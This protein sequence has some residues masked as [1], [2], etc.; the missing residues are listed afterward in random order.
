M[1][2]RPDQIMRLPARPTDPYLTFDETQSLDEG[3]AASLNWFVYHNARRHLTPEQAS[4]EY[5]AYLDS[6]IDRH[7]IRVMTKKVGKPWRD[8]KSHSRKQLRINLNEVARMMVA[9]NHVA[10]VSMTDSFQDTDSARL[11]MYVWDD[12]PEHGI[13]TDNYNIIA[14][15]AVRYTFR[16]APTEPALMRELRTAAITAKAFL[17]PCADQDLVPVGNGIYNMA[18]QSLQAFSPDK[19]FTWKSPVDFDK[20]DFALAIEREGEPDFDV[21]EWF[22]SLS[23]DPEVRD[24]IWKLPNIVLRPRV[25]W[26]KAFLLYS[27]IGNNGK[28]TLVSVLRNLVGKGNWCSLSLSE[29]SDA[30]KVEA[31]VNTVA[32]LCDENNVGER[33]RRTRELKAAITGD[34]FT[35]DAKY[36]RPTDVQFHGTIVECI[37]ELPEFSDTSESMYRRLVCI[38]FEKNFSGMEDTRIKDDYLCRPE[39]L[40]G[41]LML[42]LWMGRAY[43]HATDFDHV[44]EPEA[45]KRLMLRLRAKK[46]P[47]KAFFDIVV[48]N[49]VA[50]W[51]VLP[52]TDLWDAYQAWFAEACPGRD[53]GDL[54]AF[55][56]DLATAAADSVT[57]D[58]TRLGPQDSIRVPKGAMDG[59]EPALTRY[60]VTGSS[61]G[62]VVKGALRRL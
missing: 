38:P 44:D 3:R 58:G 24:L 42:A 23:D 6:V 17:T 34:A 28:G 14:A 16:T 55:R 53:P 37:N 10:L 18:T 27:T 13:Y 40:R 31:M 33:V 43:G 54:A 5:L 21:V 8:S 32:V 30:N 35:L 36:R 47:V 12:L 7:D 45:C 60:G 22:D 2:T 49:G 59:D 29:I 26:N 20:N 39:I 51:T 4:S 52:V 57:W 56:L 25:S 62:D 9:F 1:P 61:H 11:M 50:R 48:Q 19:V 46:N 41:I 15:T